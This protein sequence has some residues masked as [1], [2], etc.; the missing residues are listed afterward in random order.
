MSRAR[1][2]LFALF[3]LAACGQQT[4]EKAGAPA[5]RAIQ[6]LDLHIEIGRYGVMLRQV[7]NLTAELPSAADPDAEAPQSLARDLRETVWAYN[8]A[9]SRLCARGLYPEVSCGPAFEPT[10]ISDLASAAPPLEEL[11]ARENA[12]GEQVMPFWDAVCADIRQRTT[13]DERAYVCAIE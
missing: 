10:W 4:G 6:P 7:E 12:V 3:A 11:Q 5:I 8:L 9:R 2:L 1:N 13:E